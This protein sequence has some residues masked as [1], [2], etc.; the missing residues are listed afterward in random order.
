[1]HA[2]IDPSDSNSEKSHDLAQAIETLQEFLIVDGKLQQAQKS[3]VNV[4]TL[5]S[6]L[7]DL[8]KQLLQSGRSLIDPETIV[9]IEELEFRA[10]LA[11][12]LL[13]LPQIKANLAAPEDILDTAGSKTITFYRTDF[14]SDVYL[15]RVENAA[16]PETLQSMCRK[17]LRIPAERMEQIISESR[18]DDRRSSG[19]GGVAPS[20]P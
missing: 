10:A 19:R 7:E 11:K 14:L 18:E 17:R 13:L 9:P 16:V 8:H 15:D 5:Q 6:K 20:R 1:M 3:G 12:A 4:D 2:A